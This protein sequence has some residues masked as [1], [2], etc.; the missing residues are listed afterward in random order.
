MMKLLEEC[1]LFVK[2]RGWLLEEIVNELD[3][4]ELIKVGRKKAYKFIKPINLKERMVKVQQSKI[5]KNK[6]LTWKMGNSLK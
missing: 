1:A 3:S 2:Q 4:V 5:K 6:K